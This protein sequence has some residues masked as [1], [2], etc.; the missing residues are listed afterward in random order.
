MLVLAVIHAL[1]TG[2]TALVGAFADGGDVWQRLVVVLVHPLGGAGVLLLVFVPRLT[3]TATLAI[4]ALLLANVIAD[5]AFAQRIV[6]GAVK[7]DWEL[8][9]AFAVVP[10]H[11]NCLRAEFPPNAQ[12]NGRVTSS[13]GP[14]NGLRT[15]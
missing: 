8:A 11:R 7:G 14:A 5:L 4:A 15:S 12:R 10:R 1:F 13:L 9:L 6:A 3:R 2:F